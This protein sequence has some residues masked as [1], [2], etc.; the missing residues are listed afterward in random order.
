MSWA[1][2]SCRA[3]EEDLSALLDAELSP[4]RAAEVRAHVASCDHCGSRFAAL[5]RVDARLA[6]VSLPAIPDRLTE[7]LRARVAADGD[8]A[9][10]ESPTR[11]APPRRRRWRRA[12]LAAAVAAAAIALYL[13]VGDAP[14]PAGPGAPESRIARAGDAT[15]ATAPDLLDEASDEELALALEIDTVEDLDVIANLELL[16]ALLSLEE[17][18]G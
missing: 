17:E 1:P 14:S 16:E 8:V 15:T 9:P 18:T 2:P 7:M 6:E 3:F 4:R 11:R 12:A 10:A 5:E 13:V